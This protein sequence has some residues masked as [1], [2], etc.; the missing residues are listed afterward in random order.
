[1]RE[2][3]PQYQA[4][5]KARGHRPRG[6]KRYLEQVEQFAQFAESVRVERISPRLVLQFQMRIAE[7][8]SASTVGS[9]MSAVRSFFQ[10]CIEMGYCN[11]DPTTYVTYPRRCHPLPRPLPDEQLKEVLC[12]L[13]DMPEPDSTTYWIWDRNRR[14]VRLLLYTGLRLDEARTLLWEHVNL[15]QKTIMVRNGKNGKDRTIPLHPELVKDFSTVVRVSACAV[16][17]ARP[18]GSMFTSGNGF[19]HIF[20]RWIPKN[21]GMR[22]TAHQLRH[23]FATS[24]LRH[25]ADLESV[26]QLMGHASLETTQRY[27][28][29]D[30]AWLKN[31]VDCLPDL[32]DW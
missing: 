32:S 14:V 21:I 28:L 27:L 24:L 9:T 15:E 10:W 6:I 4:S 3:L 5:L 12:R 31:A 1:M 30:A 7:R 18:D 22:F 26:R 16:I 13:E 17:P 11:D 2:L 29:V 25:G 23:T 8:L 19:G 20:D